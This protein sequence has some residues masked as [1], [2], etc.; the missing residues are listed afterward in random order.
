MHLLKVALSSAAA[1]A[2]AAAAASFSGRV[3][4]WLFISVECFFSS[5]SFFDFCSALRAANVIC[6]NLHVSHFKPALKLSTRGV[7]GFGGEGGG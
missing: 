7:W 5:V 1:V 6:M 4:S 3:A 2:V